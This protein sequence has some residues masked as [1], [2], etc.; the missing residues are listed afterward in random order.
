MTQLNPKS[1]AG[2]VNVQKLI[3]YLLDQPWHQKCDFIPDYLPPFPNKDTRPIFVVRFNDGTEH[4]PFLR[5]SRGPKQ[6]FGWDIYGDNLQSAELAVIALSQAPA[7]VNVGPI[8]FSF[9]LPNWK[10]PEETDTDGSHST[11]EVTA[12]EEL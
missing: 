2:S 3:D 7:P 10:A 9:K 6:G 1:L 11:L 12:K 4:P 8:T 5:H